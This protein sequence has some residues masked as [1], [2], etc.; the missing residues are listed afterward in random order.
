MKRTDEE[1]VIEVPKKAVSLVTKDDAE[2]K[3]YEESLDI[4]QQLTKEKKAW[5]EANRDK[6]LERDTEVD[7][8][9]EPTPAEATTGG[10]A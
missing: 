6:Q 9:P 2:D 7:K 3:F 10:P 1:Y 5:A 8:K 4:A